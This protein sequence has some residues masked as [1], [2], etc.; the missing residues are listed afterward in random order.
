MTRKASK[1]LMY[2]SISVLAALF[3]VAGFTQTTLFRKTL[4]ATLYK[5]VESNLNASVYF[6]EIR[7]NI[8]TG[9]SV[10]TVAMYVN[11]AS[12]VEARNVVISY[13]PL[14]LWYKRVSVDSL[15]IEN[16]SISLIRFADGTWNVDLLAKK[17]S[18]P[19]SLPSPWVVALK[20]FHIKDAHFRLIDSM[21]QS[22]SESPDQSTP[23][24]INF[25]NLELQKINIELSAT[26]SEQE[27]SV[28]VKNISF[29]S[30][31]EAFTLTKFSGDI[32]HSPTASEIKNLLVVTPRSHIELSAR[33]KSVDA[34]KIKD[35]AALQFTPVEASISST[36]VAA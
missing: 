2:V 13:D 26:L 25:S 24:T 23:Q 33:A 35:I 14:P 8:F 6:G 7:G 21:S 16:P 18:A 5:L 12:F 19:D 1:I 3:A 9:F 36:I 22:N 29:V 32:H 4:R 27:Q 30:P 28:S 34:L 31:R 15:E 20:S 17:K 10:D 11:N